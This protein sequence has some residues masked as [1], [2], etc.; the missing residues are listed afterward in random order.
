[1]LDKEIYILDEPTSNLDSVSEDRI[2]S[3]IEKYLKDKTCII[4]THR[5]KLTEIC[6]KHYLFSNKEM[7]L[8]SE[9]SVKK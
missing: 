7:I 4:V 1:M 8:K 3:M 6:N 9:T 2:A 5:P